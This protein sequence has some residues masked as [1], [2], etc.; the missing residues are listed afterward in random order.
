MQLVVTDRERLERIVGDRNSPVEHVCRARI[1]LGGGRRP[2]RDADREGGLQVGADGAALVGA[3][4]SRGGRRAAA[5]RLPAARQEAA[6]QEHVERVLQM[7]LHEL[8]SDAPHWSARRLAKKQ[9][10]SVT[11]PCRRSGPR[12]G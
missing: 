5:G 12:T 4:C 7:T 6:A 9:S 3:L 10:V 1:V 11:V 8:P 2:R